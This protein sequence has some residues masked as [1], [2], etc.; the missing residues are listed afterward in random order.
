M[1]YDRFRMV[2]PIEYPEPENKK[3]ITKPGENFKDPKTFK[4]SRT[5]SRT[6]HK[7]KGC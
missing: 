4:T 1:G 2:P 7:F 6:D 3:N 5:P